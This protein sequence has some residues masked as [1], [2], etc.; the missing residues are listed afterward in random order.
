MEEDAVE[1]FLYYGFYLSLS[2]CK[3][4][5]DSIPISF[6]HLYTIGQLVV[7]PLSRKVS[8]PKDIKFP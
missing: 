1:V 2:W 6:P 4:S 3:I 8:L 5:S 7:Y